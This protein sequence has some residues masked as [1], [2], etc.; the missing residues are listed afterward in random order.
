M[1]GIG[2]R[3]NKIFG[4]NNI[5]FD[6]AHSLQLGVDDRIYFAETQASQS[7]DDYEFVSKI[8]NGLYEIGIG[9]DKNTAVNDW[10]FYR[11]QYLNPEVV[12]YI[13]LPRSAIEQ[14]RS[15]L[16]NV[17]RIS[18]GSCDCYQDGC[19]YKMC[20]FAIRIMHFYKKT[21]TCDF[22][23]KC[24]YSVVKPAL[25]KRTHKMFHSFN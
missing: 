19:N 22:R 1:A 13:D 4:K 17:D 18:K 3:L 5:V 7:L 25:C 14:S 24:S 23:M 2:V 6:N 12:A 21:R 20:N 10:Y 9:Y 16:F 8:N 11:T 15:L